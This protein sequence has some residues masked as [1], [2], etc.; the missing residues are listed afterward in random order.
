MDYLHSKELEKVDHKNN[1]FLNHLV[2]TYKILIDMNEP[3]DTCFAGLFHS[4]YGND[5]FKK[6]IETDREKIKDLIGENAERLVY[7][8]N[9]TERSS[10]VKSN[11]LNIKAI[12]FANEI[13]QDPFLRDMFYYLKNKLK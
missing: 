4:I 13:E 8:F 3:E 6:Q 2:N 7:I 10:L 11:D 12:I 5:V 9:T 1:H